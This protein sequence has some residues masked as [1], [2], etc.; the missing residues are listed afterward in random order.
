MN[1]ALNYLGGFFFPPPNPILVMSILVRNEEDII[2]DN[3]LFHRKQGVDAFIVGDNASTDTTRARVEALARKIPIQ[4][5]DFPDGEYWQTR[6]RTQMARLAYKQY[7]AWWVISNDADEFWFADSGNLKKDLDPRKA[8]LRARRANMLMAKEGAPYY[9]SPWRVSAPI[10]YRS[11]Y[12][13]EA[14]QMALSLA[15]LPPKVAVNP[16]GLLFVRGGNHR[17]FHLWS[18]GIPSTSKKILIYHFPIRGYEE[19]LSNAEQKKR[20]FK[21]HPNTRVGQHDH[22]WVKLLDAGKLAEEYAN[23]VYTEEEL[24]LLQ[25]LGFVVQDTRF[26][27]RFSQLGLRTKRNVANT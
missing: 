21:A 4:I 26:A 25:K 27:D 23:L 9:L 17:A 15:K 5:L 10:H 7:N 19:F 24:R 16:R 11:K 22:R 13:K 6:W 3:I 8:I 1:L 14:I 20:I 18:W 12:Q 2:E